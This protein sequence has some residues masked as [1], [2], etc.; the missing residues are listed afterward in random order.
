MKPGVVRSASSGASA[1]MLSSS[2]AVTTEAAAGES[3]PRSSRRPAVT[4]TCSDKEAG[5]S[6]IL[7]GSTASAEAGMV[8]GE[9]PGATIVSATVARS[10]STENRP[11]ASVLAATGPSAPPS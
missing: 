3:T 7:Y 5:C 9:N 6:T 2:L 1:A 8:T 11:R 4:V 10:R